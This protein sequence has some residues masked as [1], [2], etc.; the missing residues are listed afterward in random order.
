M[1]KIKQLESGDNTSLIDADVVPLNDT[2]K[3]IEQFVKGFLSFRNILSNK[4]EKGFFYLCE[5]TRIPGVK[6][7]N[8]RQIIKFVKTGEAGSDLY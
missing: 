5:V 1:C 6:L 3:N 4:S 2:N 8:V 7:E